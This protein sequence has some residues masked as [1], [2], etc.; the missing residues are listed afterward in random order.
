M[1]SH[2]AARRERCSGAWKTKRKPAKFP[3]DK[4]CVSAGTVQTLVAAATDG[5]MGHTRTVGFARHL[6]AAMLLP[7]DVQ[8]LRRGGDLGVHVDKW[9]SA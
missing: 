5:L 8:P 3:L 4:P 9:P 2:T 1:M 7:A 6:P